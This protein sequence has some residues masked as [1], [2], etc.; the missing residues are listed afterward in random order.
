MADNT[1]A[2]L[3]ALLQHCIAEATD[4]HGPKLL[5]PTEI[6]AEMSRRILGAVLEEDS[7]GFLPTDRI[8]TVRVADVEAWIL[9]AASY[10][11]GNQPD[12]ADRSVTWRQTPTGWMPCLS[13]KPV[14]L[15]DK[16]GEH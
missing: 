16:P 3:N 4:V 9:E 15:V 12:V 7:A 11:G 2:A 13:W 6:Y 5:N 14:P 10:A 8:I 1:N